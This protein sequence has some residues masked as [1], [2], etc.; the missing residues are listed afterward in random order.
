MIEEIW[1]PCKEYSYLEVS[2]HGNVRS[3]DRVV[4]NP[5]GGTRIIKSKILKQ[6]SFTNKDGRL[7]VVCYANGQKKNAP[8]HRLVAKAFLGDRPDGLVI[9]HI[10]GDKFNNKASNL[11]FVTQKENIDHSW[12]MGLQKHFTRDTYRLTKVKTSDF[13]KIEAMTKTMTLKEIA[14]K[15]DCSVEVIVRTL[16]KVRSNV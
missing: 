16:R 2:S 8:I 6:Q 9:N 10:D 3:I 4:N 11:E 7:Y 13:E 1:K 15:Y 5:G 12:K 14:K